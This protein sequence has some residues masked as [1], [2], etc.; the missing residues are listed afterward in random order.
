MID[1]EIDC[2]IGY[3]VDEY[4]ES[5]LAHMMLGEE[6]RLADELGLEAYMESVA[7]SGVAL[8]MRHGFFPTF[9]VDAKPRKSNP[10]EEW[11]QMQKKMEP[12]KFW[13]MWRPPYR[14]WEP[15]VRPPWFDEQ[16]VRTK[17]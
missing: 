1:R 14:K 2:Y 15:G 5:G 3:V 10:D 12:M 7:W 6:C 8:W 9:R 11:L 13:P 16:E 17:L 4:R